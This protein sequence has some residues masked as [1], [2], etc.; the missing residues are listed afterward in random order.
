MPVP[1]RSRR[2]RAR[3]SLG[4]ELASTEPTVMLAGI[5]IDG[6]RDWPVDQQADGV[7]DDFNFLVLPQADGR[8]R[9]YGTWDV[10]RPPRFPGQAA[11]SASWTP[12]ALPCLP[13]GSALASATPAAPLA[14]CPMTDTWT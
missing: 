12:P 6:L 14:G 13:A 11:N 10:N 8:C 9:L 1:L 3:V 2:A 4:I 7:A 5:L